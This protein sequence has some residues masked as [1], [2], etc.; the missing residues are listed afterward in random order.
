MKTDIEKRKISLVSIFFIF[1]RVGLF[2]LGGGLAMAAVMRHELV[3]KRKW[4]AD[5][6]F[7]SEMSIATI[8]PGAIAV[9]LSYLQGK[10][11]KG[12]L[13]AFVA[14]A[15]TILP[16]VIIILIIRQFA[17]QYFDLPIVARFFKGCSIG[18]AGLLIYTGFTFSRR[19]LKSWRSFFVCG[20]GL[21]IAVGLDVHPVW[22]IVA[23][24]ISGYV[25]LGSKELSSKNIPDDQ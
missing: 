24:G 25:L 8:I 2:T 5:K 12:I 14:V 22:A 3:Q 17:M 7:T 1:F 6:E 9:N 21:I 18:V 19:Q 20:V 23:A 11:L 13:G 4:I 15:G 10:K 16:S